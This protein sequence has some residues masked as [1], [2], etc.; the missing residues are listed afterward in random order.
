MLTNA[1]IEQAGMFDEN[2]YPVYFDD[3]DYRYRT[4]LLGCPLVHLPVKYTHHTSASI[5]SCR[6]YKRKNNETF[7][8]L[9]QYYISKWGGPPGRETYKTP[10][11]DPALPVDYWRYSPSVNNSLRWF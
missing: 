11:N 5:N 4:R 10:F 3:N 9:G 8:R 7:Q 6:H 1:V 2:F